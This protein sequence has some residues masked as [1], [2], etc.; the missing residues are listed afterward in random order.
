MSSQSI[1]TRIDRLL[2]EAE[3]ALTDRAWEVAHVRAEAVRRL[4][5]G[6]P[7]ALARAPWD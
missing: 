5:P 7:D 2:D 4:D 1:Q 6:N 3:K